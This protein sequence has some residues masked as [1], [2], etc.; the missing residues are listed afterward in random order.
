MLKAEATAI[1]AAAA[2][3]IF[4]MSENEDGGLIVAKTAASWRYSLL[5]AE[6]T[7]CREVILSHTEIR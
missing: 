5:T 2:T 7:A 4:I 6:K 3:N 1:R